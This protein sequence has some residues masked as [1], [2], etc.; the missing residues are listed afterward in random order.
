MAKHRCTIP[1]FE[2]DDP[3]RIRTVVYGR[4]SVEV[5]AMQQR[6]PRVRVNSINVCVNGVDWITNPVCL[7]DDIFRYARLSLRGAET[8][9]LA[10]NFIRATWAKLPPCGTKHHKTEGF[11]MGQVSRCKNGELTVNVYLDHVLDLLGPALI[12]L[13]WTPGKMT[14]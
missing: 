3:S 11:G 2:T 4:G 1:G 7:E 10:Y 6:Y 12:P 13:Y 9:L 14:A 8:D 5:E